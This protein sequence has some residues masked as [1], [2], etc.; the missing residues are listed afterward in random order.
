MSPQE[1]PFQPGQDDGARDAATAASPEAPDTTRGAPATGRDLPRRG[2]EA[3]PEGTGLPRRQR[4]GQQ[5]GPGVGGPR[6]SVEQL[7]ELRERL[8]RLNAERQTPPEEG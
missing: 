4:A 6:L 2:G 1:E 5:A 8:T 7:A 3:G